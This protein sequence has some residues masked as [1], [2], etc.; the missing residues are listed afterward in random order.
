M[1]EEPVSPLT[2]LWYGVRKKTADTVG[3]QAVGFVR[4]R[5]AGMALIDAEGH[6]VVE[7]GQIID[8]EVI[9]RAEDAEILGSLVASVIIAQAQD[10]TEK[11]AEHLG[12]TA[13]GR[14]LW[15]EGTAGEYAKA[16]NYT[17]YVTADDVTDIR[18]NVIVPADK[19]IDETDVQAARAAGQLSALLFSV[20]QGGSGQG[21][22]KRSRKAS[23]EQLPRMQNAFIEDI[24]DSDFIGEIV[25]SQASDAQLPED[26]PMKEPS[27]EAESA[28][29][30]P[31]TPVR[32][33]VPLVTRPPAG[34]EQGDGLVVDTVTPRYGK[35]AEAGPLVVL[36]RAALE[37]APELAR[38]QW[39]AS[40]EDVALSSY[41]FNQFAAEFKMFLREA[42][43]RDEWT[44]WVAENETERRLVGSI[45]LH[46][47]L[48]MP[49]MGL[50]KR[51]H[52]F[53]AHIY[54]E[55]GY[56]EKEVGQNLMDAVLRSAQE[57]GLSFLIAMPGRRS[58]ALLQRAG[59][60]ASQEAMIYRFRK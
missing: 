1:Y 17:G 49:Q 41:G 6:S 40:V 3:R 59:F 60:A 39:D 45:Y 33:S 51:R 4:G 42:I 7:A 53:I 2:R 50:S 28:R 26:M 14:E 21:S 18:G 34:K 12:R 32:R 35:Q 43:S 20:Q 52:G 55:P 48:N 57:Q 29:T 47:V 22:R 56:R 9:A 58:V 10:F 36:R 16:L 25:A 38:L 30:A 23:S 54:V 15:A 11:A 8:D 5:V 31:I 24:P 19:R 37:D 13:A 46:A 27:A 44:I